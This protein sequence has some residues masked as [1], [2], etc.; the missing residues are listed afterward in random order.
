MRTG[1]SSGA[2]SSTVDKA[3]F[4]RFRSSSIVNS[5]TRVTGRTIRQRRRGAEYGVF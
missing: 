2:A 4:C 1:M 5:I 3:I